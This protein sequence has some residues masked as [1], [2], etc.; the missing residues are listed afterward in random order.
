[1]YKL[2][3]EE[4]TI[5][6]CYNYDDLKQ[7]VYNDE[8][9]NFVEYGQEVIGFF[10]LQIYDENMCWTFVLDGTISNDYLMK[11]VNKT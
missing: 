1:M 8:Q 10:I 5:G 6:K 4:L 2:N 9:L 7:L 11:F 3:L